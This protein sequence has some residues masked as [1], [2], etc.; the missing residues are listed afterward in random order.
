MT[1]LSLI[2]KRKPEQSTPLKNDSV[3]PVNQVF[4]TQSQLSSLG[5][6]KDKILKIIRALHIYKAHGYVDISIRMIMI[7]IRIRMIF[8]AFGKVWLL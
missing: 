6:S 1:S 3:L 8:L 2:L 4:L 5:F 7:R